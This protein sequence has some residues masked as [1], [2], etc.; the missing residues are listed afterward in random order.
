MIQLPQNSE[1][2]NGG[3]SGRGKRS[4]HLQKPVQ[5]ASNEPLDP[6]FEVVTGISFSFEPKL[7]PDRSLLGN[8]GSF[9]TVDAKKKTA[10]LSGQKVAEMMA[11]LYK[12]G[13]IG[14]VGVIQERI[15]G[16]KGL[17]KN[18]GKALGEPI[19]NIKFHFNCI[20]IC[21]LIKSNNFIDKFL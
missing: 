2:N 3:R 9:S 15:D 7:F 4:V 10:E 17:E 21:I 14:N 18:L 1:T 11:A 13:M 6:E 20:Y 16:I 12:Q 19:I 5:E 8:A